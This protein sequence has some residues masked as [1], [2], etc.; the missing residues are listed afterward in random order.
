MKEGAQKLT[1]RELIKTVILKTIPNK[2]LQD[3]R[4]ANSHNLP[5]I[6]EL[7]S[8]LKPIKEADEND[9]ESSRQKF[10]P[11]F[12]RPNNGPNPR[13]RGNNPCNKDGHKHGWK[14]CPENKYGNKYHESHQQ[15]IQRDS[16][17][18]R[19]ICFE[20]RHESNTMEENKDWY[21]ENEDDSQDLHDEESVIETHL[22]QNKTQNKE[23]KIKNKTV[24]KVTVQF[25][26]EDDKGNK[27]TYL[28]LLDTGSTS[29]LISEELVEKF[30]LE[31]KSNKITWDTNNGE[32]KTVKTTVK[33]NLRFPQFTNKI[34]V[35]G[36]KFYMNKNVEQK[37]KILLGSTF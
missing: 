34:K 24:A 10:K 9:Q 25:S 4:R 6:E 16:S 15:N 2:W 18:E 37:Y 17:Q 23:N 8:V 29:S 5:T 20:D 14:D 19:T 31:T 27:S 22:L 35:T 28:G 3:L 21:L 7:Q 26:L 32:F 13:E 12:E 1:E 30:E 33:N 11:R 36:A